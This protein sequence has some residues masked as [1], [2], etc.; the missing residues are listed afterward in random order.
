MLSISNI[1]V[2]PTIKIYPDGDFPSRRSQ[3]KTGIRSPID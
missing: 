2:V 3:P 1:V